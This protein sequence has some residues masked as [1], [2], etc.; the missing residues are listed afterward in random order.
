MHMV[1]DGFAFR[2][3]KRRPSQ[4]APLVINAFRRLLMEYASLDDQ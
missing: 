1:E 3:A 2:K 4:L